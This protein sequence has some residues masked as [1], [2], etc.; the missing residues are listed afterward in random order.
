M[1]AVTCEAVRQRQLFLPGV[2]PPGR[3]SFE[4]L[5]KISALLGGQ[6]SVG[7]LMTGTA[8]RSAKQ[9]TVKTASGSEK[10]GSC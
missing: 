8:Q 1:S 2:L 3:A 5:S 6:L 10:A 9:K 7:D 4:Q